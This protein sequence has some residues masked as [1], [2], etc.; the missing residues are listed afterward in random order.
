MTTDKP[1]GK[2]ERSIVRVGLLTGHKD[3]VF[4]NKVSR[5]RM[6]TETEPHRDEQIAERTPAKVVH[7]RKVK[8]QTDRPVDKLPLAW[9]VGFHVERTQCVEEHLQHHP[10][11]LAQRRRE[12]TTFAR[13]GDVSVD[14]T[15]QSRANRTSE[16]Q[17]VCAFLVAVGRFRYPST[18]WKRWWSM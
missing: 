16:R 17:L 6:R 5:H 9:R 12:E 11:R 13:S 4:G 15:H 14:T 10:D 8:R 2:V 3:I 18:P 7:E 1:R